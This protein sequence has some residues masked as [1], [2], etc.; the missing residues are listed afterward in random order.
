MKWVLSATMA[1]LLLQVFEHGISPSY[2]QSTRRFATR[3]QAAQGY[4]RP[5]PTTGPFAAPA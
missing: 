2:G 1:F 4:P 5:C 3:S